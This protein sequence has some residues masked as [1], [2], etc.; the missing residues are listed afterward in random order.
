MPRSCKDLGH[1]SFMFVVFVCQGPVRGVD[2]FAPSFVGL[3]VLSVL[4]VR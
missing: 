4:G 1:L 2:I 3:S